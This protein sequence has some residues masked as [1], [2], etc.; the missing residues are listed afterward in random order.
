E[1]CPPLCAGRQDLLDSTRRWPHRR[2]SGRVAAILD[3]VNGPQQYLAQSNDRL[4]GRPKVLAAAVGD[5]AHALLHGMVLRVDALDAGVGFVALRLP[6]DPPTRVAVDALAEVL[7][8]VEVVEAGALFA[9][10]PLQ[11]ARLWITEGVNPVPGHAVVVVHGDP[12]V[13]G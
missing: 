5:R 12:V 9:Q 6:V 7:L 4:V 3:R 10:L 11:L 2:D 13:A 8:G 1:I